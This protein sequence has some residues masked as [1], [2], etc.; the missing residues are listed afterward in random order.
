MA[1]GVRWSTRVGGG[2]DVSILVGMS[3]SP[4]NLGC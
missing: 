3:L 4:I 1:L 2:R